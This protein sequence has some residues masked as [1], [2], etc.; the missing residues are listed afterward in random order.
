MFSSADNLAILSGMIPGHLIDLFTSSEGFLTNEFIALA[1]DF[2]G[3]C[4]V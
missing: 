2:A 4:S 1:L 3:A